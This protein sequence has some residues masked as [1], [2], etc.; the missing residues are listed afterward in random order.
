MRLLPL[1]AFLF[2]ALNARAAC[3]EP[4]AVA[5]AAL[6]AWQKNDA[7]A[8]DGLMH[9]ELKK[10]L[11][12]SNLLQFYF[13]MKKEDAS[14]LKSATDAK[15]VELFCDAL[16]VIVPPRDSRF[17]YIENYVAT[18]T[19]GKYAVVVFHSGMKS[20][21]NPSPAPLSRMEVILKKSG[22]HWLFLWSPAVSIHVDLAWDP[23]AELPPDSN[24]GR[25]GQP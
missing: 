23:K 11:R 7:V 18:E 20:K 8:L 2:L 17:E 19:H 3:D 25:L 22:D 4:R 9:P 10:R 13:E 12:T 14:Q 1:V 16:R 5:E 24:V 21:T 15:V 6:T